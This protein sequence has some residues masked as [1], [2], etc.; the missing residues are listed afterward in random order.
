MVPQIGTF[1]G[2]KRDST[3][4]KAHNRKPLPAHSRRKVKVESVSPRA[5]LRRKAGRI[6]PSTLFISARRSVYA[7]DTGKSPA[8]FVQASE[9]RG[10][11]RTSSKQQ[12]YYCRPTPAENKHCKHYY[13]CRSAARRGLLIKLPPAYMISL[14]RFLVNVFYPDSP[15]ALP[16]RRSGSRLKKMTQP[17]TKL[18]TESR[19]LRIHGVRLRLS[20]LRL[21]R[22]CAARQDG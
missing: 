8:S 11:Q 14:A 18:I 17:L 13:Y 7:S 5:R 20:L 22:V 16:V 12:D 6:A 21:A 19:C 1:L 2:K 3:A 15:A 9:A 10:A 4:F